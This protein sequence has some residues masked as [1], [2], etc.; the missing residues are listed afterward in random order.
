[1]SENVCAISILYS[2]TSAIT[3][4]YTQNSEMFDVLL[5]NG[6]S[7]FRLLPLPVVLIG[8]I[9]SIFL[10]YIPAKDFLPWIE[11]KIIIDFNWTELLIKLEQ[12]LFELLFI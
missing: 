3:K 1:M 9:H 10:F 12:L 8:N 4:V 2:I 7:H 5:S 11:N 6:T